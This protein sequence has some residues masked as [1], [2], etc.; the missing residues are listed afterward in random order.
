MKQAFNE[1]LILCVVIVAWAAQWVAYRIGF[2]RGTKHAEKQSKKNGKSDTNIVDTSQYMCHIN[3]MTM[4]E[5]K[6]ELNLMTLAQQY[7]DEDKA[8]GLSGVKFEDALLALLKTP[9]PKDDKKAR[10]Q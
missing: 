9:V 6:D 5:E 10:K 7:S 4:T 8:R 1:L 3:S 2:K